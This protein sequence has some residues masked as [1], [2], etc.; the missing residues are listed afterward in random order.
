MLIRLDRIQ[1]S[2]GVDLWNVIMTGRDHR[3]LTLGKRGQFL[4]S[5]PQRRV[6]NLLE[7]Y[8][9]THGRSLRGISIWNIREFRIHHQQIRQA[10]GVMWYPACCAQCNGDSTRICTAYWENC[11]ETVLK[12]MSDL[13]T[14]Y[15]VTVIVE[16]ET[17][18][19]RDEISVWPNSLSR[20]HD[21][22]WM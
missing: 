6:Q 2:G 14:C 15:M 8:W 21:N 19:Q 9:R 5:S 1:S 7:W 13:Q 4:L 10:S 16:Q 3:L 12:L 20:H 17:S 18:F 11:L 22:C